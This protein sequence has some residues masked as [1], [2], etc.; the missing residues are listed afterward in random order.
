MN[1]SLSHII[2]SE[3]QARTEQVDAAVSL[4]DEGN[5][6][7]FI[8][9]YR[10]EVTGGL[11]DTQLRQLETRLGYL[12][13]LEDRRQTILKS[14]D[15]QGK[16]T[17]QLATAING[18]LSKT[19]L[20][21]LYLPYKPKRRT[22]GQIAI[23]AGL[24]PLADGLWQDPS[25]EPELTAQAYVD[26]EKG[27][28]DVKAALD[29]ARY[30]LMERFAEDATLLAKVRHY[31]WKNAHL[32]S[33]VVEGKEEEG[34]KF[35]DYFDHHEPIAQ[36]PSH[37]ALAMFR[38]RNEGVLQL[39]LNAD[40]Q[41]EEAPRESYC[42]Q[43]IID[44]LNLRLGNAAADSWRRA[45]ISWTWRIKVLLH[46]ETELMGSVR[47]KAEDEAINVFARN[48]HDLLMAAPAGMRATMGLD[49]GLRTGVK[50]AVVDATGKLVA[51]DTIYPHT[52]Q[53]AKAAPIIAALCLKHQVELVAIGNGTASRETERF[54]L[55]TQKQFPDIKA[56]KVIVSEAGASVYSASELAALEFPDLDVSLRGAV[57]I[58]RRLQ[59]PLAELVKIDP[60]SIGVGQYQHDVSQSLLAKKLDAVVEDCVNAVGVDL[61]TASVALLTR[62]A[63]LTRMMAQNIVTWRDENGRFHN[64]EQL[65]KV[66]R[67]GP[68]AFEQCAG[69]LRINNGNNPLDAST[70]HP[71]AYPIVERILAA[72]E[73]ALQELMGNPNALRNLKPSDFTDERFGV[74]TVTDIIKELEKPGRD[75]RPEFKTASFADGVETLNDLLPGMI[76]EGAVTNVTNFGAFVDIGVH[77]DGLVHISSLADHFVDDPHKVVKAGDI[78]KVKVM[79][80]DLQRKRIALT[81][82]LDEQPGDTASRRGGGNAHGDSNASSRQ[83]AGK[84]RPRPASAPVA[85]NSAMG[86]ALAAAF[87]KR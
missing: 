52:G 27:V 17:P 15:E 22:R 47:E 38:G 45:V 57:S 81:M 32:V 56:Q 62:V 83:P 26:A 87:K 70:V 34:A 80:V 21:D 76:L 73:Q 42:E 2:A 68:K 3:L 65:L 44:H 13:E 12:R 71:E 31:L 19:E 72:T 4:L 24:E 59:D 77:Q 10:K 37:R 85:G 18:T 20:E 16:L 63:G 58:A 75:P 35:R 74:P 6:V 1:D 41:H 8:A 23:E 55:D 36:V 54:F 60:K 28:A 67:L 86:D 40:P 7:P 84:S 43:I 49:P 9:R 53:A 48:M 14:I 51:T 29:G 64:R 11:D 69:F 79:E 66:S 30:I 78:V 46:L 61:N 82:R 25:Q 33:R 5:T 39:A 50:V